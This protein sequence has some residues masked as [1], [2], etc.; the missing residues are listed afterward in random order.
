MLLIQILQNSMTS[1]TGSVYY[2]TKD[3]N[4]NDVR[5]ETAASAAKLLA[6]YD[7]K[8]LLI[9]LKMDLRIM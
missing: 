2:N 9:L 6:S 7:K 8:L 3:I 1:E 4:G 5:K